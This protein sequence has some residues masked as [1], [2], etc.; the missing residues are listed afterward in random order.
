MSK[1]PVTI[2]INRYDRSVPLADGRV[3]AEG[4]DLNVLFSGVEQTFWRMLLHK[5]FDVSEM[6][7]S[8]YI[9]AHDRG[10]RDFIALPVFPSRVFRHSSMFVREDSDITSPGQL[11]GRKMGVP[12]YQ[13][14]AAVWAKGMIQ[15]DYGVKPSDIEWFNGGLDDPG[16]IEKLAL[17]LPSNIRI[18][19]IPQEDTLN[20]WLLDGKIDALVTARPPSSFLDGTGR[21]RRLM[22]NHREAEAAY[23]HRTKIYPPMHTVV[24]RRDLYEANRWMAMSLF[25]AFKEALLLC[26]PRRMFDGHLAYALPFLPSIIEELVEDFGG[27]DMW[28]Y[29]LEE[30]RHT[31]ETLIRHQRDQ[32]LVKNDL[33]IE[34]LFAPETLDE[35]KN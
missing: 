23:Y 4:I 33:V 19:A 9:M 18:T 29:G 16:R 14:T 28:P 5:E 26:D 21:I 12:E 20:Q 27:L 2:A 11:A 30:N 3:T 17:D 25:K 8:S 15:D 31:L 7:L 34:E 32:G 13:M 22:P 35:F 1:L 6:S 10:Q 24:I